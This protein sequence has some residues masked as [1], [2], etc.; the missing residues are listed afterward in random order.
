MM[1]VISQIFSWINSE[2]LKMTWLSKIIQRLVEDV[3]G[4]SI[5]ERLG[6]SIHFSYMIL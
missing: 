5:K 4:L 1:N 2:I 3:F 6:G